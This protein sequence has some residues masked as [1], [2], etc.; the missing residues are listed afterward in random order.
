M[1]TM[2]VGHDERGASYDPALGIIEYSLF[3]PDDA[4]DEYSDVLPGNS[5][6]MDLDGIPGGRSKTFTEAFVVPNTVKLKD[7]SLYVD[8]REAMDGFAGIDL[9]EEGLP[10]SDE[11]DEEVA[12]EPE[13]TPA[14]GSGPYR[15]LTK[16]GWQRLVKAP[17]RSLGK[18]YNL[19]ACIT[20]FDTA[21]GGD[22]FLAQASNK[23][24][25]YWFTDG[26]NALFS[27]DASRLDDFVQ[28][29]IVSM[30][31]TSLGSVSYDTQTGG[32]TTVP[33][34]EV[35]S[36]KRRKGSC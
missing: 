24:Q 22:S 14:L 8:V 4:M 32:N 13:E 16:R 15:K 19:F 25:R 26:D 3:G 35:D 20:Q 30:K 29:D 17:D 6:S 2:R 9:A 34:F 10:S 7:L 27:G 21:T 33:L 23:H 36:I 12:A 11:A 18:R 5:N 1:L 31:V 28:D